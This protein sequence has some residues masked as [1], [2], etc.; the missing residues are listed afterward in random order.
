MLRA[1]WGITGNQQITTGR[2]VSQFGGGTGDTFYN[3]SGDGTSITQGFRQTVI[4]NPNLKWEENESINVGLDIELYDGR[5]SFALDVYQRDTDNL[6][7]APNLPA[8]AGV[9]DPPTVNI[10]KMRNTGLDLQLGTRGTINDDILWSVNF[11]GTHYKNEILRIDGEQE[12][13]AGPIATRF[14]NQVRNQVGHPISAFFGLVTDGYFQDAS[15]VNAHADQDGAAP[16]RL[17]F[18]DLNGDGIVN[19]EDRTIIGSPHPDFTGGLD[20][21]VRWRNWSFNTTLFASI[22]NDIW[23]TQKEFYVFRNF[24]TNVRKDVLT[25][26]WTPDNPDAKYPQLDVSDTFSGQQLSDF[27]VEDGSYLRMRSLQIGYNI[28]SEWLPGFRSMKVFVQGEN[29]FTITGYDGL[30]PSLPAAN[31]Q[32]RGIDRGSYPSSRTISLGINARF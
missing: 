31:D 10:G 25:D 30:D 23:D 27:Y 16:G 28:P 32:Y 24:S 9:A 8:T 21:G 18:K 6:L 1:G 2:T 17:R 20:L 29:L 3:I 19:S 22:G 4:G 14:G 13:F 11:N 15:E 7:F 26:S 12:F 5:F